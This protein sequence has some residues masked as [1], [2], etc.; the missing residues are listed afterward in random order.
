MVLI[1]S[2]IYQL[3]I[4]CFKGFRKLFVC[5]ALTILVTNGIAVANSEYKEI[6]SNLEEEYNIP[7][8][9]LQAIVTVESR[10]KP[11][12]INIQGV[13]YFAKSI[14]EAKKVVQQN[15]DRGITNIDVG[16]A[17][18]NLRWHGKNFID[19]TK[20]IEPESN[21]TYAANL[22]NELHSRHRCWHKAVR[23]YHSKNPI[24][25]KKYSRQVTMVW[26]K[27]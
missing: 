26:L 22:L 14:D 11:Y 27:S 2:L 17:Q 13:P 3:T 10:M 21:L 20:M 24:Y 15:I 12:A 4:A 25:H 16:L 18:V 7:T 23:I 19:L 6:I 1:N 5:L 9:L 8:G